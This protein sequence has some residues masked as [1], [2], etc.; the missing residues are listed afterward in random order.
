MK[1]LRSLIV[2]ILLVIVAAGVWVY[3]GS[4]N[5]GADVPHWSG[6]PQGAHGVA[7]AFDRGARRACGQRVPNLKESGT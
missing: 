4:Y 7:R 2:L 1:C 6:D 3:S 5:I